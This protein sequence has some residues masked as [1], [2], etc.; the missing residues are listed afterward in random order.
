MENLDSI[1]KETRQGKL[2]PTEIDNL[3][4][5]VERINLEEAPGQIPLMFFGEEIR[6]AKDIVVMAP[7][8][9][10]PSFQENGK[11][12]FYYA[13]AIDKLLSRN[14]DLS[15]AIIANWPGYEEE[16]RLV[17]C[18]LRDENYEVPTIL[19][20]KLGIILETT[21]HI[22]SKNLNINKIK[23][24]GHST[25]GGLLVRFANKFL[26]NP[27]V[28][29]IAEDPTGIFD[30]SFT[31]KAYEF[32][33]DKDWLKPIADFQGKNLKSESILVKPIAKIIASSYGI[34]TKL[35][36]EDPYF[37]GCFR[38]TDNQVMQEEV[39]AESSSLLNLPK[40][41]DL[42]RF[43]IIVGE[44]DPM[45]SR[46]SIPFEK[47]VVKGGGHLFHRQVECL[48]DWVKIIEKA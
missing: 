38:R 40:P 10:V 11:I 48:E 25:A 37:I 34:S 16:N 9:G 39:K 31:T 28:T 4:C 23:I 17:G 42:K 5:R 33:A 32:L 19:E 45:V 36:L 12:Y 3:S 13:K 22:S 6:K 47:E 18:N 46:N 2:W 27:K 8:I 30:K 41:S 7:G 43:N 26:K 14:K 21:S 15:I 44:K 1:N 24:I 20:T 35:F 29:L